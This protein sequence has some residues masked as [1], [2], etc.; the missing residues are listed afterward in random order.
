[1]H[2]VFSIM[3][4]LSL[5][6]SLTPTWAA[7]STE[8]PEVAAGEMSAP[9]PGMGWL[10]ATRQGLHDSTYWLL[11]HVDGW[12]GDRPF[13]EGGEVGGSIRLRGLHRADEGFKGSVRF[14]LQVQ[15]PNLDERAYLFFGRDNEQ[16]LVNDQPQTFSR[17]QLLLPE[18]R[19]ED[20]TFFAGIGY[21][22]LDNVDLR[23]GVRGG[24]KVYAQARYR[25][26]WWLSPR[27]NFEFRETL[28]VA[29]SDG[30]GATTALDYAHALSDSLAFRWRNAGT[31]GSETDGLSWSSAAGLFQT[32]GAGR[33]ISLEL[34]ANG[35]TGERVGV[36]EY[37]LRAIYQQPIYRDWLF[38]EIIVGH[39]WPRDENDPERQEA[40][41]LGLGV[42]MAF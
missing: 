37:G 7:D 15:M 33:E 25:M 12:F 39:F 14:R 30:I 5:S 27:A 3:L 9:A 1:M 26:R 42:E 10:H 2:R 18:N 29:V 17:A 6:L 23:L 40:W 31:F 41:A 19:R 11:R 35:E 36:G 32:L 21:H 13:E 34:L 28:F 4:W 38:G 22:L 16:E 24:Y 8:K 20:E